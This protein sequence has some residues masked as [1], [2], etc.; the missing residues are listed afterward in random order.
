VDLTSSPLYIHIQGVLKKNRTFAINTLLL[1]LQHFKH[2]SL[3]GSP[4]YWRYTIPNVSSILG[5]VPGTHSL[6]WRA[7]NWCTF[8][9]LW[10]FTL[11]CYLLLSWRSS[12]WSAICCYRDAVHI[13]PLFVAVVM[14]LHSVDA[15]K[16]IFSLGL[17]LNLSNCFFQGVVI[18]FFYQHFPTKILY[19]VISKRECFICCPLFPS[20]FHRPDICVTFSLSAA[21][22]WQSNWT[23]LEKVGLPGDS[24]IWP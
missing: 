19:A 13:G 17:I 18:I 20:L 5:M 11:V 22:Y 9:E 3:Q 15:F 10:R 8:V 2:Y 23:H 6:W 21:D 1:I 16:V 7:D 4:F 24:F 12:H 14:Q